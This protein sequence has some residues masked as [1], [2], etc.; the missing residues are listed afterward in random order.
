MKFNLKKSLIL[1]SI[2][3]LTFGI[4]S[5]IF[6]YNHKSST[7]QIGMLSISSD[8]HYAI[9]T[10]IK[11][12]AIL[13]DIQNKQ[14]TIIAQNTNTY[15]AYWIKNTAYFMWQNA[16]TKIVT[17]QSV[18]GTV[19]KKIP[20]PFL[21]VGEAMTEDLNYLVASNN[22]WDLYLISNNSIKS[23]AKGYDEMDFD[24]ANKPVNFTFLNSHTLL[25]SGMG[26]AAAEDPKDATGIFLWNLKTLKPL[27]DYM[28]NEL[29]TF[30]TI[31]PDRQYLVAGDNGGSVF[32][33]NTQTG[34]RLFLVDDLMFGHYD[35]NGFT[36]HSANPKGS[37]D[38]STIIA[39]MPKDFDDD[40]AASRS[41]MS[42]KFIDATHYLTFISR[43]INNS[44]APYAILYKVDD[45]RAQKYIPLGRAPYP[46]LYYYERD[47]AID[48]A[49]NAHILVMGKENE[50]GI[51]V[52][53]YDPEKQTLT[54]IWNGS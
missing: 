39:K 17:V 32:V 15:S 4:F 49:P 46:A 21:V 36:P 3:V 38:P 1:F 35:P 52:Y 30:G 45:P 2:V 47:Q 7:G 10:D 19:I 54:K 16:I 27:H 13:W 8:G 26:S 31:S 20:L 48:T 5:G 34:K 53:K 9:S 51:L 29:Q 6:L 50:G 28:G 24:A 33:W 14:K 44:P 42:I 18:N 43:A 11:G 41:V 40:S 12:L 23:I 25:T 22:D 37:F